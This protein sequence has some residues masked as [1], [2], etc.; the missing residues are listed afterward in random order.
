MTDTHPADSHV[1]PV[2]PEIAAQARVNTAQYRSLYEQAARD[3][4]GFW[5]AEARKRIAWI[6]PPTKVKNT[7]FT[8]N[9]SIKWFDDGTLNATASCLD[10]HLAE[11]GDQTAII[12][13]SDDPTVSEH[14]TYR[15]LHEKVCRQIGRAHV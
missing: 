14:V 8:G 12:W 5:G 15:Q 4:D 2:R 1:I 9:V 6:K 3:P 13:E 10:R 11:R 7:S